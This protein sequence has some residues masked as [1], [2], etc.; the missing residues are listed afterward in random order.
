MESFK[1]SSLLKETVWSYLPTSE[2]IVTQPSESPFQYRIFFH[3]L[4]SDIIVIEPLLVEPSDLVI[5]PVLL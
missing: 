4:T 3:I 5:S 2:A 1:A